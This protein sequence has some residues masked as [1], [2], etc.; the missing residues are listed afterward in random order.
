[1]LGRKGGRDITGGKK[2]PV[3]SGYGGEGGNSYPK[4]S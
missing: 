4:G 3:L 2:R 1:M